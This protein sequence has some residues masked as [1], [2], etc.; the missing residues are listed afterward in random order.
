LTI[1]YYIK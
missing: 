1:Q